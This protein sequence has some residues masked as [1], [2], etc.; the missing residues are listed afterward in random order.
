[1]E[2]FEFQVEVKR[3]DRR[4]SASIQLDGS[5]VRVVVPKSLSDSRIRELISKRTTW[6]KTKLKERSEYPLLKSKEYVSGETFPYLGKNYRLKVV[7][8]RNPSLKLKN[9][10]LVATICDRK[11]EQKTIKMLLEN[12]YRRHAEVRLR[13]KTER[14]AKIVGISPSSVTIKNYKSRWGSCSIKGEITYNWRIILAPHRIVDY[15]VVHELCH[16]LEHNH[17]P[18]YWRH[19]E[20]N[21]DDLRE[22][23]DWLK[24]HSRELVI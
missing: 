13:E 5:L 20:S 9:G 8:G 4:K 16:L 12:W 17:S 6:I 21:V 18:R 23:R 1:M 3:T 10:F 11:G 19:V 15:V 2:G 24:T 22:C 7:E 14:L